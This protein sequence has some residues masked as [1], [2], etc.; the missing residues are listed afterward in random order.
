MWLMTLSDRPLCH[1]I[2]F[3]FITHSIATVA[4]LSKALGSNAPLTLSRFFKDLS[5][6]TCDFSNAIEI[7]HAAACR[8]KSTCDQ[9]LYF[10]AARRR[11]LSCS[12][13]A[14]QMR[15]NSICMPATHLR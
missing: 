4:K 9:Q 8:T 13:C 2:D 1:E 11:R 14:A 3:L 7:F 10:R 5:A 6:M 15:Q 12:K